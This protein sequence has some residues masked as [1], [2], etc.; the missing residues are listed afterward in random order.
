MKLADSRIAVAALLFAMG[1][2]RP[3][4]AAGGRVVLR[5]D[6]TADGYYI[7]LGGTGSDRF[8][9]R[10]PFGSIPPYS[11]ICGLRVRE[12]NG[13][14]P[15]AG[16]MGGEIRFEDPANPLSPDLVGPPLAVADAASTGA[17]SATGAPRLFTFG[18]GGGV[19]ALA[20]NLF[21]CAVEPVSGPTAMDFCG[22]LLDTNSPNQGYAQFY[23]G[24]TFDASLWNVFVEAIVL[25]PAMA[26]LR[27][28]GSARYPGDSGS[29]VVYTTRANPGGAVTDDRITLTI[30]IDNATGGPFQRNVAVCADA[31]AFFPAG[32]PTAITRFL[33]PVGGGPPI[34]N[35][36]VIPPGRTAIK[37]E[38]AGAVSLA[39]TANL[40]SRG[41]VL[42]PLRV[43]VDDPAADL[44]PCFIDGVANVARAD[45]VLGLRRG[46]G[47]GDDGM[48]EGFLVVQ[49]PTQP[50]DS[51]E[52]R[53]PAIDLPRVPY[54]ASGFEVVGG[55][56]GGA[57][58]PGLD[59]LELRAED[60]VFTSAPDL[61]SGGLLRS[62]G[63]RDGVGEVP[64]GPPPTTAVFDFPDFVVDPT[65]DPIA[66]QRNVFALGVI[67]P[68]ASTAVTAIGVDYSPAATLLGD[69]TFLASGLL[70]ATPLPG[71][72][73][74][75]LLVD[76]DRATLE[77]SASPAT[78]D[79]SA[80]LRVGNR[81]V[82]IDRWGR[83]IE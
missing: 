11:I 21:A 44:S 81:F 34:V 20:T 8:I 4:S 10:Y 74:V 49:I 69:S 22:V 13:G 57:G 62:F 37:L 25:T 38:V 5:T 53:Y 82:A 47:S 23:S 83:R 48:A 30:V 73:M 64:L 24:G 17:C 1:A 27:A 16:V 63:T 78:M 32:I 54:V 26:S 15:L 12:L 40:V 45:Q 79:A 76:G 39:R 43:L 68:G 29:P 35:P 67:L 6:N 28:T 61:S 65:T 9:N 3:A 33:T 31:A 18:G 14:Q 36:I 55:D 52:V 41:P 77:G 19:A 70:P 42:L 58:L 51:I 75:R 60:P 56:Y 72:A 66:A 71:N 7:R 59:A 46:P 2:W 50:G 80:H